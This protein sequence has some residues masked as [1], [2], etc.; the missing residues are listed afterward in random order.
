MHPGGSLWCCR[1]GFWLKTMEAEEDR[2]FCRV[3]VPGGR[4]Q[5]HSQIFS[6][7]SRV[8]SAMTGYTG[9]AIQV[10]VLP[11]TPYR[12]LKLTLTLAHSLYS[13]YC[14]TG[15]LQTGGKHSKGKLLPSPTLSLHRELPEVGA[16]QTPTKAECPFSICQIEVHAKL[17]VKFP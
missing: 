7:I 11:G 6:E 9:S 4:V 15:S 16:T 13:S 10:P 12:A 5:C 14:H 8:G 2:R 17:G 3:L 1:P